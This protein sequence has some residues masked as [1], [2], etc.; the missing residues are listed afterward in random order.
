MYELIW[1]GEVIDTTDTL[2]DAEYLQHEYQIAYGDVVII[3][4]NK[5]NK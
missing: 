5:K 3:K 4:K 1:R 2:K